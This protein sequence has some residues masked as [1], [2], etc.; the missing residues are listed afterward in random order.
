MRI[1][2]IGK[3]GAV[4][5]SE[6]LPPT[7]L[8][9]GADEKILGQEVFGGEMI[10]LALR[11]HEI[12]VVLVGE[13]SQTKEWGERL[14]EELRSKR[15][16]KPLDMSVS[17]EMEFIFSRSANKKNE[18]FHWTRPDMDHLIYR[19]FNCLQN[20]GVYRDDSRVSHCESTKRYCRE[21]ESPATHLRVY[22]LNV[23]RDTMKLK[24]RPARRQKD[25]K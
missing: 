17:V 22:F 3:G 20:A 11:E 15:T 9:L 23:R 21:N 16:E 12:S 1:L 2:W 10:E 24:R 5:E 7:L 8:Q 14:T 4:S 13:P 25:G 19:V 6:V 18:I